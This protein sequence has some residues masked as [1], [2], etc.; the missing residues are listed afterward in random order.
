MNHRDLFLF[1]C[2]FVCLGFYAVSTVIQLF[3]GDSSQI[4]VSWTIFNQYL[5]SPL[6]WHWQAN[7]SAIPII[8]NAKGES[9][10]DQF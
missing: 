9:H 2:L 1:V 8:L 3:N 6:S 4:H 10:Y 7:R 5:T